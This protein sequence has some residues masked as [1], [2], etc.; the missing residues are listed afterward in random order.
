[1]SKKIFYLLGIALVIILGTILY[2]KFCCNC[3]AAQPNAAVE[4]A[5]PT[6]IKNDNFVPFIINGSGFEFQTNDN[7]KFLK[8]N[9][10]AIQPISDSISIG[11]EKLKT[12]LVSNPKQKVT[13]TGYSTS[14]ETNTT[15]FENL[16]LARA[17][18]VKNYFVSKGLASSQLDTKGEIINSWKTNADTLIGPVEYEFA[19]IGTTSADTTSTDEWSTLKEKIN[20]NPLILHFNTN[21]SSFNLNEEEQQKVDDI[22]KYLKNVKNTSVLVVGHSDNVG[23]RDLNIELAQKRA[24]FSKNYLIKNGIEA[25][26]IETESKGPDEPIGDNATT[27]GKASNRRTVITIK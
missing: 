10:V 12:F 1:M 17:N 3:D 14:D 2:I 7:F 13:I 6:A 11:I 16:G 22:S 5:P 20:A 15:K 19:A 4:K 26:R 25:S 27:E 9:P 24:D 8:N 21:K 18:D 23:N